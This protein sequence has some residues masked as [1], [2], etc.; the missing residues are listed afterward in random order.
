MDTPICPACGCSLVRLGISKNEAVFYRHNGQ[1]HCFCCEGCLEVFVTDPEQYLREVSNLTVCPVCLGE[2]RLEST[3][4]LE[5]DGTTL[6]FCR[7]PHCTETFER[8]P[9]HYMGRLAG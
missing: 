9:E 6:H 2:K 3:V 7:C 1:E 4:A 5:H 8:N